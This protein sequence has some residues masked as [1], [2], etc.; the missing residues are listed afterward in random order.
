MNEHRSATEV[1]STVLGVANLERSIA[2][3]RDVL[4]CEPRVRSERAALLLAPDGFQIYLLERG[5]QA[6]LSS[7]GLGHQ[8]VIWSVP[9]EHDL[10]EV[11]AALSERGARLDR[12][13]V[14]SITFITARDPDGVRV[15]VAHPSPK[16]HPRTLIPPRFFA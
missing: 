12:S 8:Y 7:R 1:T 14:D 6:Q 15:V 10:E 5:Q 11:A 3:Y 16:D 4:T 9:S 13:T 2:F